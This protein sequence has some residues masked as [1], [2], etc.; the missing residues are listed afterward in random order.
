MQLGIFEKGRV[1]TSIESRPTII[2]EIKAKQFE[3][4]SLN[5]LRKKTY[6]KILIE[7]HG[8]RYTI[9][10]GVTGM[11]RDLKRLYWWPSMKKDIAEFIA[12]CQ[13]FRVDYNAQQLAK[14]YMKEIVRVAWGAPFYHLGP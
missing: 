13:N 7:S 5:E 14:V 1:L 9:H 10:P 2:E 8:S 6:M 4:E 3:D 12:K 11:Y